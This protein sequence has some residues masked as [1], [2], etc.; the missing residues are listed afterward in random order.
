SDAWIPLVE[1]TPPNAPGAPTTRGRLEEPRYSVAARLARGV[2]LG[3]ARAEVAQIGRTL[4]RRGKGSSGQPRLSVR[5]QLVDRPTTLA[6]I[7]P[8]SSLLLAATLAL[9]VIA[10]ANV[11]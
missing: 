8:L 10:C 9:L 6:R 2:S 11:A 5:D 7:L 1:T 3:L 4:A